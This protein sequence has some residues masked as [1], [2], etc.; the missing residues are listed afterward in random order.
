MANIIKIGE[1]NRLAVCKKV[2]F[3]IYLDGGDEGE[4]LMPRKYVPDGLEEG[5]TINAFVYLD[6]EERLVATMETPK[7]LAGEFACLECTWVNEYGA[8]LDWGVTKDLFCPFREQKSKMRKGGRYI[9]HAF[10]DKESYRLVASAK[11]ERFLDKRHPSY[12]PGDT[13]RVLVWQQ[14]DLGYKVI[15]DNKY[16]GL[17]YRNEI[18]RHLDIGDVLPAFVSVVRDDGKIDLTLQPTGK[19]LKDDV[20]EMIL[21]YLY[22]ND[23]MCALGDKSD[24]EE[25][26]ECFHVSK[27][28]FKR[29]VGDL[30]KRRL[31]TIE[32]TCI[33]LSEDEKK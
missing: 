31:I 19:R 25:I 26:K 30:Y 33:R 13:V 3:G 16:Y 23:G 7:M 8:F 4:I 28:A 24:A 22:D 11:I 21:S 12:S 2:D 27:K 5:D 14:T 18:Y 20:A 32:P 6:Q 9:V 29:A 1:Y 15:V 10:I 17:I